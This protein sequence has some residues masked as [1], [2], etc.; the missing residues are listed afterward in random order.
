MMVYSGATAPHDARIIGGKALG[1]ARLTKALDDA[2]AVP[3]FHV[4]TTAAHAEWRRTGKLPAAVE[5]L[6][7]RLANEQE[8]WAVR[9]SAAHEDGAA[10]SAAGL[11]KTV[12]DV[13]PENICAAI[14][15]VFASSE[16]EN[17][18]AI[19]REPVS[20][21]VVIQA[22]VP[23]ELAGICFTR[24]PV[25]NSALFR[26]EWCAGFGTGAVEGS[27]RING[28]LITRDRKSA[29]DETLEAPEAPL[30]PELQ[31]KLLVEAAKLERAFGH[32]L[33]IEW[34]ITA[35]RIY[36]LQA[37]PIT[38]A[39]AP[40]LWLADD[41]LVESYPGFTRPLTCDFAI[42]MYARVFQDC[43]RALG[44]A[45]LLRAELK[46]IHE[47]MVVEVEGHL[48]YNL[49]SYG[50]A[51]LPLPFGAGLFRRWK[52]LVDL[53]SDVEFPVPPRFSSSLLQK[54]KIA[55]RVL[56]FYFR[57]NTRMRHFLRDSES[58]LSRLEKN[59][60]ALAGGTLE[61]IFD[62]IDAEWRQPP[63]LALGILNDF[64]LL[65]HQA[66]AGS[67]IGGAID[68]L[69]PSHALN[70]LLGR[71]DSDE[72]KNFL[73]GLSP[74]LR[75]TDEL[76]KALTASK[77]ASFGAALADFLR[78]YGDRCY[79]DLKL[80]QPTYRQDARML[81]GLL[82]TA[83]VSTASA[84]AAEPAATTPHARQS[85]AQRSLAY[86]EACRLL[87][88]RF[89]G[90][91]RRAFLLLGER[92]FSRENAADIFWLRFAE[93]ERWRAGTL[94][95]EELRALVEERKR[96]A[97]TGDTIEYPSLLAVDRERP[98]L[99]PAAITRD[100][101]ILRGLLVSGVG[102]EG[103]VLKIQD[104]AHMPANL[105]LAGRLIVTRT[106]DPAWVYWLA[107]VGGLLAERGGSLSHLAII[108]REIKKP[109]LVQVQGAWERLN[110]GDFVRV[111][112]EGVI[113]VTPRDSFQDSAQC[114]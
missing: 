106:T 31:E 19:S 91:F 66:S 10:S 110:D 1:L 48:Y 23:A 18:R 7:A 90:W 4:V 101:G 6:A 22:L 9:S 50:T 11:F 43:A 5:E 40:L 8:R 63:D 100:S 29:I 96:A 39:F 103:V 95:G 47:R 12:L 20:M 76:L 2:G 113:H 88:S 78:D 82:G 107:Q 46:P 51:L 75:H 86:R 80:E 67:S 81:L 33:D 98:R 38:R 59:L 45:P 30:A 108:A 68:S 74:E 97:P 64:F 58:K 53:T 61:A 77:F 84:R 54:T 73:A 25:G 79:G 105:E 112:A 27:A 16:N 32:P 87:R 17:A 34:A 24:N 69:G 26:L 102:M 70:Q 72:L 28:R 14:A 62:R 37:R 57:Q 13:A 94:A 49:E 41:N 36:F 52:K 104:P 109:L 42:R 65:G 71:F 15:E 89:Y 55:F 56:A 85:L 21:A 3:R 60:S 83:R 99:P 93:L 35:G 92:L 114:S 44:A 111:D